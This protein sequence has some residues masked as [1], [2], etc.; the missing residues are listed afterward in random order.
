MDVIV[1]QV[2]VSLLLVTTSILLF[3]HSVKQADGDH[4]DRLSLLALE[5][6]AGTPEPDAHP[7]GREDGSKGQKGRRAAEG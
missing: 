3:A 7:P 4:A 6:D 5:D 2:F 1:L